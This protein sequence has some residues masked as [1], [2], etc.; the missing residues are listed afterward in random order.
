[1]LTHTVYA[2]LLLSSALLHSVL[3]VDV[4]GMR[5]S[6]HLLTNTWLLAVACVAERLCM[7]LWTS[8]CK[9]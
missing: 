4:A 9:P 3:G 1:M 6:A 5:G 7:L 8:V 2:S